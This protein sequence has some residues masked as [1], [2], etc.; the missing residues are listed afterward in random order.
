[1]PSS[2]NEQLKAILRA[3]KLFEGK[4]RILRPLGAGSFAVVVHGRHEVMERDV[5]LK[6][7][8]PKVVEANP[9]VSER[10]VKEVQI[11]SRLHHP[12]VVAIYDFG[13]TEDGIYYMVQEFVDGVT[14]D[15]IMPPGKPL[16]HDRVVDVVR[17]VLSCLEEAHS[18]GVIHRDLKP[19]NLMSTTTEEG[20]EV[21]KILDFGVAKLLEKSDTA[22]PSRQSTKFIGTPIYMSPEQILGREVGPSSDLYSVGLMLYEMITGQAPIQAD[23]IA[24]VVQ[25]HLSDE[26]FDFPMLHLLDANMQRV[27]LKATAR[28]PE[29]RFRNAAEFQV[30]LAGLWGDGEFE[31]ADTEV[32][33]A[34]MISKAL[35]K[36]ASRVRGA[37]ALEEES[38]EAD[39]L[40]AFLGRNYIGPDVD[41]FSSSF[42]PLPFNEQR[43]SSLGGSSFDLL[44]GVDLDEDEPEKPR[45]A[46]KQRPSPE[47]L[48]ERP[49]NK[50]EPRARAASAR[51][52]SPKKE[53]I[54]VA[55]TPKQESSSSEASASSSALTNLRDL[56]LDMD[57]LR[58]VREDRVRS[59]R[60]DRSARQA[61][62]AVDVPSN[63]EPLDIPLYLGAF[64]CAYIAFV[65]LSAVTDQM[66]G[67]ARVII[68]LMP[69]PL[70]AGWVAI[71]GR[72]TGSFVERW[73]R[74]ISTRTMILLVC[75]ILLIALVLPDKATLALKHEGVW[76]YEAL[77]KVPPLTWFAAATRSMTD[78]FSVIF[79]G[80]AGI[81][82]W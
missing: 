23:Q 13:K 26:R 77:P 31:S 38:S 3:G 28:Q 58:S 69:V 5:A 48:T 7:L 64:V 71:E 62:S 56:E 2:A 24:E 22:G 11:A 30:A 39:D 49:A 42:D 68:G 81:M 43:S 45:E 72:K 66:P 65:L 73:A 44:H 80:I 12:N 16:Q 63:L 4:Y 14:V 59:A 9:E 19:S 33:D 46:T 76:F 32:G 51:K 79:G 53:P 6:F 27:I 47:L 17:Q 55:P 35:D 75:A 20:E 21:I 34:A 60:V 10:F 67:A 18:Q 54:K 78:L 50:S 25:Q 61:A 15:E 74:P 40:D 29:E 41:E 1:M 8:K 37:S 36:G 57:A 82:P 70:A 52:E